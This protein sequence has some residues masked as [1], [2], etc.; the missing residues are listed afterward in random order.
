MQCRF[1]HCLHSST[2]IKNGDDFV[3]N[4]SWYYHKDCNDLR[5]ALNDTATLFMEQVN[6]Q[7]SIAELRKVINTLCFVDGMDIRYIQFAIEFAVAHPEYRLTYPAGLYRICRNLG[8]QGEW[9]KTKN[10]K[11]FESIKKKEFVADDIRPSDS[12]KQKTKQRGFS[13]ILGKGGLSGA[14]D[15]KG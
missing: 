2:E 14:K 4:G 7:V 8:I 12:A 6:N 10:K 1:K 11:W 9:I 3:K 5:L 15:Q 13:R